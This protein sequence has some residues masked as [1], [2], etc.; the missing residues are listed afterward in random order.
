ML[1]LFYSVVVVP[2]LFLTVPALVWTVFEAFAS[3]FFYALLPVPSKVF[4]RLAYYFTSVVLSSALLML[5]RVSSKSYSLL[6]SIISG[7]TRLF[8]GFNVFL[9]DPRSVSVVTELELSLKRRPS[10]GSNPLLLSDL[11]D[12]IVICFFSEALAA[13]GSLYAFCIFSNLL[14]SFA[15]L[16]CFSSSLIEWLLTSDLFSAFSWLYLN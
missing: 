11:P 7:T 15:S 1:W 6:S 9:T 3:G 14:S 2:R 10:S 16:P 12:I 4:L 13:D 5:S 8:S